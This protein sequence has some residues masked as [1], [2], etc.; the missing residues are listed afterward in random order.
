MLP[1]ISTSTD[2]NRNLYPSIINIDSSE[3]D[4]I[5]NIN[6]KSCSLKIKLFCK[7]YL[8][9]LKLVFTSI[10][11]DLKS[12]KYW[13]IAILILFATFNVVFSVLVRFYLHFSLEKK[14]L[15]SRILIHFFHKNQNVLY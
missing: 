1:P 3:D 5:E 10:I 14:I 12:F 9:L 7:Q 2:P 11:P 15:F 4:G 13:Q 6:R 8:R